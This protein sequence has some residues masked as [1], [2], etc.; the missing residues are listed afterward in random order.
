MQGAAE[1]RLVSS[2]EQPVQSP[3]LVVDLDG[4]LVKTD[5]LLESVLALLKRRP[6]YLFILPVWLLKGRAYLKQQIARRVSLDVRSLPYR[7]DLLDYL[8]TQHAEGRTIALA[9]AG[10]IQTVRQVADHVKLF[11]LIFA[12]DG[13]TNLSGESKRARLVSEFGEKGFDYVGN[14][15]RDLV[16]WSSARKAI[17]VNPARLVGSRIARVAQVDRVFED[18]RRGLV[19]HLK[20]FR[21]QHWLKNILVFVPLFAALRFHEIDLLGKVLLAFLAFGCF[22][23]GGYLGRAHCESEAPAWR[24]GLLWSRARSCHRG[25]AGRQR[26]RNLHAWNQRRHENRGLRRDHDD[27]HP[28]SG[29]VRHVGGRRE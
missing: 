28:G 9:T 7:D 13:I 5:L 3:A 6:L 8:K 1:F 14:D 20:P 10:D 29:T 25:V 2:A 15:R 11:D 12:S 19:D 24:K 27:R 4:T 16:V 23:S 18:R 26:T 21:P 22:A 17:L